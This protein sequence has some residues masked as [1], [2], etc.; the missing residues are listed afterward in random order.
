MLLSKLIT[1]IY[2]ITFNM[3][4]R[5]YRFNQGRNPEKELETFKLLK[6]TLTL[7]G[8]LLALL[9]LKNLL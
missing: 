4:K 3:K 6:I 9:I 5:Q 1:L 2:K 7:G 8:I